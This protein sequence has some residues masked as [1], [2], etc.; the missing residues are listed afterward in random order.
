[1]SPHLAFAH[2][3]GVLTVHSVVV[4]INQA[5]SLAYLPRWCEA[6]ALR[7]GLSAHAN[8]KPACL[9]GFFLRVF[10]LEEC[11][12]EVLLS[13][14]LFP[15]L[16]ALY[17]LVYIHLRFYIFEHFEHLN[18]FFCRPRSDGERR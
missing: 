13:L 9:G 15:R 11:V 1:M 12:K 18:F 3:L 5:I 6:T 2:G 7:L 17:S 4:G 14:E 10:P 8:R 16:V